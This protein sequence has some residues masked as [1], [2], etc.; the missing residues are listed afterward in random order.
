MLTAQVKEE[1]NDH[2]GIHHTI[3]L[4]ICVDSLSER[5]DCGVIVRAALSVGE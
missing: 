3:W 1:N 4:R 5:A 2:I